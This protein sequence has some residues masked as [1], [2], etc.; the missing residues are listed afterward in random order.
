[1]L[2]LWKAFNSLSEEDDDVNGVEEEGGD[3]ETEKYLQREHL[4]K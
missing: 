3:E 2:S 1:M 4:P